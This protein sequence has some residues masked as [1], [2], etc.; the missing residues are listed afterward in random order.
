MFMRA[1]IWRAKGAEYRAG[2]ADGK[3]FQLPRMEAF[4]VDTALFAGVLK[5]RFLC[6]G[7]QVGSACVPS[8]WMPVKINIAV[9]TELQL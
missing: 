3:D 1:K 5:R 8:F 2:P 7:K 6:P 9:N 4:P